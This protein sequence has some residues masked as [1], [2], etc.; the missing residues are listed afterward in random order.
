MLL[1]CVNSYCV[2]AFDYPECPYLLI[3]PWHMYKGYGSCVCLCVC[4]G[5]GVWV[6]LRDKE[7][8]WEQ[9]LSTVH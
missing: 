8:C 4:V 6:C 2:Y 3:K 7:K 9:R 1:V 5:V